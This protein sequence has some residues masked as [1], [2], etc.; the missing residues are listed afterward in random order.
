MFEHFLIVVIN[1]ITRKDPLVKF[2]IVDIDF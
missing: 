1:I 2:M